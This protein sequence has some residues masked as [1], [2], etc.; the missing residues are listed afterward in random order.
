MGLSDKNEGE[1]AEMHAREM[2]DSRGR[3]WVP[4]LCINCSIPRV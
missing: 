2:E 3:I 1:N 4:S